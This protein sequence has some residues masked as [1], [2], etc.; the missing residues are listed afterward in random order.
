[1]KVAIILFGHGSREP[2][3]I[4][5]FERLAG[6]IRERLRTVEVRLAFLE[7]MHPDLGAA[8]EELIATG[9]ESIRIVPVFVGEGGHIR[10]DLPALIDGLRRQYPAVAI[11]CVPAVGEDDQVLDALAGYCVRGLL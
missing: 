4:D 9:V 11:E 10:S 1:V 5:P 8:A 6:R 7:L 2:R 3:W